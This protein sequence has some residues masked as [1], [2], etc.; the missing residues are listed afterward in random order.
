V[1]RLTVTDSAG[2]TAT[3]TKTVSVGP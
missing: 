3:I 2:G 1:V